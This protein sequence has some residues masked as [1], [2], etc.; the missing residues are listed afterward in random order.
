MNKSIGL[1]L[2]AYGCLLGGVG[3]L[4]Y[5][6]APTHTQPTLVVGIAGGMLS[7]FSGVQAL[8]ACRFKGLSL[9]TLVPTSF[10]LLSQLVHV[11]WPTANQPI[12]P[13]G[14]V[15]ALIALLLLASLATIIRIAYSSLV[16]YGEPTPP[17]PTDGATTAGGLRHGSSTTTLK[18]HV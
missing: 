9:L 6:L 14:P 3:T 4:A 7:L 8:R 5:H 12:S 18:S 13:G 1:Q 17:Q 16:R 2:L 11:L 10:V 15:A